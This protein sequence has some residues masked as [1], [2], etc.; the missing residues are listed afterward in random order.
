MYNTRAQRSR[1]RRLAGSLAFLA[2]LAIAALPISA[3]AGDFAEVE[4]LGFSKSGSHFAFEEFG[5]QDGSGFPYSNIY[6]IDVADDSWVS[7]T[8]Q[9]RLDE[10]DDSQPLDFAEELAR[11]RAANRD[12]AN[13]VLGQTGIAGFG[14]TV[15]HNPPTERTSD[16][17]LMIA[18]TNL[19]APTIGGPVTLA[20][21]EIPVAKPGN[22]PD[23]FGT[24]QGMKL[25]LTHEGETRVLADDSH[26]PKSRGCPLRYRIERFVTHTPVFSGPTYFAVLVLMEK[27]GF[28]GPDGR[29]LAI[30]GK[31]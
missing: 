1:G 19:S 4:V 23:G 27:I 24:I 9:R 21:Q 30:T 28:E 2:G 18:T 11:T 29:F 5:I 12:V 7:G 31:L 20:L 3:T 17:H 14:Q 22:C 26:I 25:T 16:P 8:P 15:G 6:L 10:V 13:D